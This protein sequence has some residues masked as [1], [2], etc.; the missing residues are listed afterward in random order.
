MKT[1]LVDRN[2]AKYFL[3]KFDSKDE[4]KRT[5]KM[6]ELIRY[7]RNHNMKVGRSKKKLF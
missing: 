3:I 7:V 5:D 6:Y 1:L 4:I 2:S